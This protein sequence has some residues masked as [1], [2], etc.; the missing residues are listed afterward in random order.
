MIY[1]TGDIHGELSRF[2]KAAIKKMKKGDT[3]I[4]CGDFGFIWDGGKKEEK[5][6]KKLGKKK[7]NILFLDGT[8]ENFDLLSKYPVIDYNGGS[9]QHICGNLYHLMRGEIYTIEDK[10]IFVFGGGES[11][12]KQYRIEADKWWEQEMPNDKEI[13]NGINNLSLYNMEVDYIITHEPA[14]RTYNMV[15]PKDT[16]NQLEAYFEKIVKQVEF[17]RWFFGSMHT[18]RKITAKNYAVFEDVIPI[19]APQRKRFRK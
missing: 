14:P 11:T 1:I 18:D 5:I 15:N 6:L 16:A 17:K 4:V 12:D 8:H 9:V 19:E 10:K 13:Q 2:D 7:Y 3:L